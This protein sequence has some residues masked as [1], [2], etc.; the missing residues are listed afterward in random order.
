[1]SSTKIK[2][3]NWGIQTKIA[4]LVLTTVATLAAAAWIVRENG[5]IFR[6]TLYELSRPEEILPSIHNII[7]YLPEAENRLRF[8]ALTDDHVYFEEYEMLIDSVETTIHEL[9]HTFN[10]D[11]LVNVELDSVIFLLEQRKELISEYIQTMMK[12]VRQ[13]DNRTYSELRQKELG[14]LQNSSLIIGQITGILKRIEYSVN[15]ENRIKSYNAIQNASQSLEKIGVIGIIALM[16][17]ILLVYLIIDSIRKINRY[18]RELVLSNIQATEL[19]K[20]KEEFLSNMSHEIRTPLNAIIG[21]SDQLMD[22]RLDRDQSRYLDAVR[23]SSKHLLETVNDILDITRLSAGH[24]HLEKTPFRL[25]DVVDEA[26]SPFRLLAGQKGLT[27]RQQCNIEA[28]DFMV[29]GDPLRLRQILYNL[30]SNGLKFTEKGSITFNCVID[31]S[32]KLCNAQFTITDTGI[33]IPGNL[34]E[35]IFQEFRQADSSM[36]RKYG[37]SGLGLAISRRMARLQGGDITVTSKEGEGSQF[38]VTIPFPVVSDT[39]EYTVA[40]HPDIDITQLKG[41]RILIADDDEFNTLLA[42]IIGD[43]FEMDVQIA[44]NGLVAKEVISEQRFDLI[45]ADLQMPGITGI[46]LIRFIRTNPEPSI[47]NTPVIAFTATKA[48]RF[49]KNLIAA[50]FNEVLQKPFDQDELLERITLYVKPRIV[51]QPASPGYDITQLSVFSGG[52]K[53]QEITILE[54][55]IQTVKDSGTEMQKAFENE[56]YAELK[57]I[58]HRLLTSY[59]HLK[60]IDSLDILTEIDS[61]DLRHINKA[62]I[63]RFLDDL[64]TK[65]QVLI[66]SLTE[67]IRKI[68]ST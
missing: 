44:E 5:K 47:R 56:D 58:A 31:I 28:M 45:L 42:Q 36:A 64:L 61:I 68:Q 30:L 17:I 46:E 6:Q 43:N 55:F 37:G 63:K 49:D 3:R 23:K 14:M 67:E 2:I 22:T 65:N 9:R 1:M 41:K 26:V 66:K 25:M 20:V 15:N 34:H 38:K 35:T 29:E 7:S 16:L 27:F 8:F 57:Y 21:F 40:E 39:S 19:A 12:E 4:I 24:L 11:S 48:G 51:R 33:G 59:G 50:G 18:R 60:V 62:E 13:Q 10:R 32:E 52:N 53:Q 54:S